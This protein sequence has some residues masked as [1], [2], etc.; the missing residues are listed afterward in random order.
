MNPQYILT[1]A[2]L[3]ATNSMAMPADGNSAIQVRDNVCC[4]S[5][6]TGTW[7]EICKRKYGNPSGNSYQVNVSLLFYP[8]M[9]L[10]IL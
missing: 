10:R 6:S 1:M 9:D 5:G 4:Q 2:M 8:P 7:G 3:L